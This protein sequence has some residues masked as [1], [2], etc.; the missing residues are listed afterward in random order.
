M[1]WYASLKGRLALSIFI[2]TNPRLGL[3]STEVLKARDFLSS[4]LR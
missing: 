4:K 2:A 1:K 3:T